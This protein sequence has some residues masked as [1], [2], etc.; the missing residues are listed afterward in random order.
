MVGRNNARH[1]LDLPLVRKRGVVG[2]LASE[3]PVR[4]WCGLLACAPS[5]YCYQ[6][7]GQDATERRDL[8]ERIALAC[9][10][11]GDRRMT[12]EL[13][14]RGHLVHHQ[15]VLHLRREENLLVQVKRSVRPPCSQHAL[16]HYPDRIRGLVPDQPPQLW[17]GDSTYIRLQSGCVHLAVWMDVFTRAIRGWHLGGALPEARVGTARERALAAPPAPRLRHPEHGVPSAARGDVAC[18]EAHG[19]QLSMATLGRPTENAYAERRIRTLKE[20]AVYLHEYT[21]YAD[22]DRRLGHFLEEAYMTKRVHSA[23]GYLTPAEC[24]PRQSIP[25]SADGPG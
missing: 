1:A 4:L 9:P 8:L 10:R 7:Q 3:D 23:L 22:A 11:Y 24:E 14:R 16:G 18:L 2:M 13:H 6:P 25:G 12:A 15:R 17:C 21:G 19:I 5:S 20:E